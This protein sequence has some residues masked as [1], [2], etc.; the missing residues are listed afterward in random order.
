MQTAN[1][2]PRCGLA[3]PH[4]CRLAALLVSF[5]LCLQ[6]DG[7][8]G[9]ERRPNIL[10]IIADDQSPMD[11]RMYDPK[12]K[13]QTPQ[14]ERLASQG[15][16]F[17]GAYHMGSYVGAVC[18]PSRHMI[19]CGR[20]VWHLPTAPGALEKKL[21]PPQLE[22][23]TI[24]AVFHRAG[25]ATMRTCKLGNSYE[26]ANKLFAVR[27]DA[28]KNGDTD[29]EGSAWH[30]QQV[31]DYLDERQ[32]QKD[33]RPFFIHFGFTHPH[34]PR[35]GKPE[36]LKKYGAVNHRDAKSI[37]PAQPLAPPLPL[38]YL[39]K[40]PFHHGHPGLRDETTVEGVWENRDEQTI[41]NEVGRYFACSENIDTQV[42]R[43]LDKLKAMGELDNTYVFYTAD[44]GIAIGRH[45]LQGKQNLYEHTWR[46]PMIVRG[47]GIAPGTRA[48]GN[49]YLLDLLATFCD[50]TQV[51][52]PSTN[53]GI[54]F[55]PVLFGSRK[56]TRETLY[57]VYCGGTKPGMR[58]IR[59][60]D[61][62][63]IQYDVLDGAVREKQLFHLAENPNEFLQEH[64][65]PSVARQIGSTPL[66]H[67]VNLAKDPKF[68][69][70]LAEMEGLLLS[71]MRRLDDPYRMWDQPKDDLPP[72][73][74]GK[75]KRAK[76]AKENDA[77]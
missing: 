62:K 28:K 53:E 13:L 16:V 46:V 15:M 4:G 58:S 66:P 20:T 57:G 71:E 45:A 5:W 10:F 64:Q 26:A 9:A 50:L 43:V 21:C 42:G 3:F 75:P 47:P 54:S 73:P 7:A 52:T 70:K 63:F 12:S 41:R 36:L 65:D 55:K 2:V 51:E 67:Q 23:Q 60:G 77:K 19:M 44:H 39:P 34:D 18:S 24:P 68:A 32:M 38:N 14:L 25:Y 37:P 11:L 49:V 6:V 74:D 59:H 72:V 33:D 31:L 1:D 17:D 48:Q 30:A 56:T 61:W 22:E 8:H 29:E 35:N 76:G 27:R 40:L 69:G